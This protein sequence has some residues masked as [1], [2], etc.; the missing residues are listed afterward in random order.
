MG[1]RRPVVDA[2]LAIRAAG[3]SKPIAYLELAGGRKTRFW[4]SGA[5]S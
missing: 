2:K 5:C 1:V 4:Y 3:T